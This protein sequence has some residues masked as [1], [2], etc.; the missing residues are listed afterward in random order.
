MIK[1]DQQSSKEILR[2]NQVSLCAG[3]SLVWFTCSTVC[4][5]FDP[6]DA[7]HAGVKSSEALG[8]GDAA[9]SSR[10][11]RE[12]RQGKPDCFKQLVQ[13]SIHKCRRPMTNN[14]SV[15]GMSWKMQA[16]LGKF[17][18]RYGGFWASQ[19][20][21]SRASMDWFTFLGVWSGAEMLSRSTL[22]LLKHF[23]MCIRY[24][25]ISLITYL[26]LSFIE[27]SSSTGVGT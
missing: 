13:E 2:S 17:V 4:L 11:V 25:S 12:V 18:C 20:L 8:T 15:L 5:V 19:K 10:A 9:G 22:L 24:Y 3:D 1:S 26:L 14:C 27:Q 6:L 7:V 21:E 16:C 23:C